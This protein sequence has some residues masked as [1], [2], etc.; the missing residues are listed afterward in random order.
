MLQAY[1]EISMLQLT[2]KNNDPIT[3]S[4]GTLSMTNSMATALALNGND[5]YVAGQVKHPGDQDYGSYYWK[6]GVP[7]ALSPG[8]GKWCIREKYRV[9]AEKLIYITLQRRKIFASLLFSSYFLPTFMA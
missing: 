2:G 5:L 8:S 3:L 4:V 9:I 1:P 7:I 6:N